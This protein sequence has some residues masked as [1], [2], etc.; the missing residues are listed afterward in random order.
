MTLVA[1][2]YKLLPFQSQFLPLVSCSPIMFDICQG[3]GFLGNRDTYRFKQLFTSVGNLNDLP[4]PVSNFEDPQDESVFASENLLPKDPIWING[5]GFWRPSVSRLLTFP[6]N[7]SP[8]LAS[9][10][11]PIIWLA[12]S[13][14]TRISQA[15]QC[16]L[17]SPLSC[18]FVIFPGGQPALTRPD[19]VF[20]SHPLHPPPCILA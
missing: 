15:R 7:I 13:D 8:P 12:I 11:L 19:K 17:R 1:Q 2:I 6:P 4:H 20:I 18:T 16:L 14:V 5:A 10:P 3:S 9:F